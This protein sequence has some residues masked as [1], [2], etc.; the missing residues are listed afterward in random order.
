VYLYIFY[1]YIYIHIHIIYVFYECFA[2]TWSSHLVIL[3]FTTLKYFMK[4][5]N[6]N[7]ILQCLW[8]WKYS[9]KYVGS[10]KRC[11]LCLFISFPPITNNSASFFFRTFPISLRGIEIR[12]FVRVWLVSEYKLARS[13]I[14]TI[15]KKCL[16]GLQQGNVGK[17]TT[18]CYH[19]GQ[20]VLR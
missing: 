8:L 13:R 17:P 5:N 2:S 12:R 15:S 14:S 18:T 7:R 16:A 19:Y 9:R 20:I 4:I 3:D 10:Q 6:A 1:T 11:F